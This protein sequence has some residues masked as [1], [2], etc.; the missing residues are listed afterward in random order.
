MVDEDLF[1]RRIR[2]DDALV[3]AA[4]RKHF[5]KSIEDDKESEFYYPYD[6]R[7]WHQQS[8]RRPAWSYVLHPVCN[9]LHEHIHYDRPVES[10]RERSDQRFEMTYLGHGYY[11]DAFVFADE[12]ESVVVKSLCYERPAVTRNF[13][14]VYAEAV[15]LERLTVSDKIANIYGHCGSTVMVEKGERITERVIPTTRWTRPRYMEGHMAQEDLDKLQQHDVHPM[16]NFTASE[17]LDMAIAMAESLAEMHGYDE[18]AFTNDDISLDQWLLSADGRI[19]LND[20]NNVVY[21]EFDEDRQKYC[22]YATSFS[23][24]FK[25]PEELSE[26]VTGGYVDTSVDVHGMGNVIYALLTGLKPYYFEE[27]RQKIMKMI[28][29]GG[30]PYID[31]RYS[32]SRSIIEKRMVEIMD[33]CLSYRPEERPEIFEV[34]RFLRETKELYQ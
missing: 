7:E 12:T 34:V 27:S 33:A 5:L 29:N 15:A 21:L 1:S 19:M 10:G 32:T 18:G 23:G 24:T 16:N 6:E 2:P 20:C 17:K 3:A 13:G 22:K 26:K 4:D 9:N 30:R 25:A 28:K 31:P 11:R 14:K 8:C